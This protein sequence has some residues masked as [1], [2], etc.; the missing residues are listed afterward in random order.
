[1]ARRVG[2]ARCAVRQ[3]ANINPSQARQRGQSLKSKQPRQGMDQRGKAAAD[4]N[5][6]LETLPSGGARRAGQPDAGKLCRKRAQRTQ[7]SLR[8]RVRQNVASARRTQPLERSHHTLRLRSVQGGPEESRGSR[9]FEFI[10]ST[11]VSSSY[12]RDLP[13]LSIVEGC[14]GFLRRSAGPARRF[15]ACYAGAAFLCCRRDER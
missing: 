11:S 14:V 3:Q 1:M 6:K 15:A 9:R 4:L 2:T 13:A 10:L 7:G 12:L 5:A 8:S